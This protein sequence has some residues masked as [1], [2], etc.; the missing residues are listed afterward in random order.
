MSVLTLLC[1]NSATTKLS[2]GNYFPLECKYDLCE[3]VKFTYGAGR[4][5]VSMLQRI[6]SALVKMHVQCAPLCLDM[7]H[8]QM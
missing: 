8:M 1:L 7:P 4:L 2:E 3:L 6:C 5:K